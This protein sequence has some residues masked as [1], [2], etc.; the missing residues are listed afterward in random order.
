MSSERDFL[1]F[2][3]PGEVMDSR[4]LRTRGEERVRGDHGWNMY[5]RIYW[6]P[7]ASGLPKGTC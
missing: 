1:L 7:S 3:P 6:S 5:V 2:L 4:E